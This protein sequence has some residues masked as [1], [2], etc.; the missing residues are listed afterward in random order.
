ML[1]TTTARILKARILKEVQNYNPLGDH[2]NPKGYNQALACK[3]E[4]LDCFP[5]G[6]HACCC[7]YVVKTK[8]AQDYHPKGDHASASFLSLDRVLKSSILKPWLCR[9]QDCFLC[10]LKKT[11]KDYVR[12]TK[13]VLLKSLQLSC[14]AL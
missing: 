11:S 3:G 6:N 8:E 2:V 13:S 14:E 10:A 9:A 1:R 12:A 7:F 5:K 4:A